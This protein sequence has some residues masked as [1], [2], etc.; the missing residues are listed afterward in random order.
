M[1]LLRASV[2]LIAALHSL[3]VAYTLIWWIR[4]G[5]EPVLVNGAWLVSVAK[6]ESVWFGW[7]EVSTV[8]LLAVVAGYLSIKEV[9][10]LVSKDLQSGS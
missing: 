5:Y 4:H 9:Y 1:R 6:A 2:L 3:V 7:V 10:A 8:L